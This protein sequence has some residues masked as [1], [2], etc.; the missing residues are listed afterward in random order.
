MKLRLLLLV[1]AGLVLATVPALA[2]RPIWLGADVGLSVPTGDYTDE[3]SVGF[4][5]GLT[6]TYMLNGS[7]GIGGDVRLLTPSVADDFEEAMAAS[8]GSSVDASLHAIQVTPHVQFVIPTGGKVR[9]YLQ[10]GLGLYNLGSKVKGGSLDTDHSETRF[11]FHVGVG[12]RVLVTRAFAWSAELAYHSIR[13]RGDPTT[14]FTL[15][16]GVHFGLGVI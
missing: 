14:L 10:G 12:A 6:G 7:L 1:L 3:A 4:L 8:A 5:A 2:A 16:G 15:A 9:P 13:T 11:G